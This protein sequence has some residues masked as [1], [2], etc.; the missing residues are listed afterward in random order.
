MTQRK[1][2]GARWESWIDRQIREAEE[3]GEFGDLPGAGKPIPDLDKPFDEMWWVR[4]KLRRE[5]L[6]Y[7]A[8]S[9]ALRKEA[10]DALEAASRAGSEREVRQIVSA[11]NEKI[12][13][14]N[15]KTIAVRKPA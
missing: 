7:M 9:V 13:D 2:P 3:R 15:R 5:G 8:P 12:R 4:D 11:I 1:P 14:A 10:H 6:T